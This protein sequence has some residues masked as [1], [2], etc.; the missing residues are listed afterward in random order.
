MN[1]KNKKRIAV[2]L[3]IILACS[4]MA[5]VLQTDFGRVRVRDITLETSQQQQLHALVFSPKY[6]SANNKVPVII[7]M[8]SGFYTAEFQDAV[9][10]ELSRRGV[11]VIAID[12]YSHGF[13]SNVPINLVTSE[14]E[15][16]CGIV[17]MVEY[18]TSGILDFIDT[19]RV[20][21]MGHS[22]GGRSVKATLIHYGQLYDQA[23][24]AAKAGDTD[25]GTE[26]TEQELRRAQESFKINAAFAAGITPGLMAKNWGSVHCNTG[27]QYGQFEEGGYANST[28]N[29]ILLGATDEA[30]A[31]VHSVDQ[32][33]MSVDEGKFYGNVNEGTLRVLYQPKVTH[34]LGPIA[35]SATEDVISFWMRVWDLDSHLTPENQVY[36]IKEIFNLGAMIALISLIV[37][38]GDM[39]LACPIFASHRVSRFPGGRTISRKAFGVGAVAGMIIMVLAAIL[40]EFIDRKGFIFHATPFENTRIFPANGMNIAITWLFVL[41]IWNFVWYFLR[42]KSLHSFKGTKLET[43]VVW[44][45]MLFSVFIIGLLYA[46]VWFCKWMFNTDFR[47]W[48]Q[49]IKSFNNEKLLYF[50]QYFPFYFLFFLS[51]SVVSNSFDTIERYSEKKTVFFLALNNILGWAVLIIAQYGKLFITG[52]VL[53]SDWNAISVI[54][55]LGWQMFLAPY[56]LRSFYQMTGTNWAG[57]FTVS[58][59]YTMIGITG[60][61]IQSA[62]L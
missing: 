54:F 15:E 36:L 45:A 21:I 52:S 47:F 39:L 26:V 22:M 28:G 37:P 46:I 35:P 27:I 14:V 23:V 6:A 18:V 34:L 7:T 1:R 24:E 51:N 50:I 62:M 59:L 41:A 9:S 25:G 17:P 44:R 3:I 8:H 4:I 61:T 55:F 12:A 19:D 16:G 53:W 42:D 32:S 5:M 48:T 58:G 43:N 56:L 40:T 11:C 30:L 10:I 49:Y 60:T 2:L 57:A 33:V 29:A 20:G 31:M 38:F 13:S